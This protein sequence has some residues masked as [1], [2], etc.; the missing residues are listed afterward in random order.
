MQRELSN[1]SYMVDPE[2]AEIL[3]EAVITLKVEDPI[4]ADQMRRAVA[5][6]PLGECDPAQIELFS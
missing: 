3:V 5:G 1:V 6:E 2:I 4:L